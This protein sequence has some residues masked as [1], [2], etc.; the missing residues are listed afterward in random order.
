MR[1]VFAAFGFAALSGALLLSFMVIP[2]GP[3]RASADKTAIF[4]I[5]ASDGYGIAHCLLSKSA[6]GEV[7]ADAWCEAHGYA[8]SE[9]YGAAARED[10][11]GSVSAVRVAMSEREIPLSITCGD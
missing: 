5:P 4:L 9:S 8:R 11:T 3:S 1:R 7:V 10:Y 2:S 6:C